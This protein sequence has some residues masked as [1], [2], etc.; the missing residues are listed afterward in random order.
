MIGGAGW[1]HH[2]VTGLYFYISG[3]DPSS[4]HHFLA[5]GRCCACGV[6]SFETLNRSRSQ[7]CVLDFFKRRY[8]CVVFFKLGFFLLNVALYKL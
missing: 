4:R 5:D 6:S 3:C 2:D 8:V 1:R 7:T